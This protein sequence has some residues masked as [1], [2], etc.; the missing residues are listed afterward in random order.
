M[1][2]KF[3]DQD[4]PSYVKIKSIET[5]LTPPISQTTLQVP[6]RYGEYDFGNGIGA[7]TIDVSYFIIADS[8]ADLRTKAREF[9]KWL[10]SDEPKKLVLLD[11]PDK[12][13]WAKVTGNLDLQEAFRTGEGK[14]QFY[15]S[16][17]FAYTDEQGYTFDP[18]NPAILPNGG[19][20][21]TYPRFEF[22]FS[23]PSS[24]FAVY[25]KDK[26]LYFGQPETVDAPAPERKRV[27][28]LDDNCSSV[29]GWTAGV[30]VDGATLY[31][32]LESTGSY[33]RQYNNDF[34]S[35]GTWQGAAGVKTFGGQQLQDFT[36]EAEVAFKS[37]A[38]NQVGRVE[39]Y[40]LDQNNVRIGKMAIKDITTR[41]DD[42]F[43]EARAGAWG[44]GK[45]FVATNVKPGY[46]KQFQGLMRIQRIGKDW[47]FYIGM[48]DSKGKIYR[49]YSAKFYDKDNL[50]SSAKLAGIQI[51]FG[52]RAG[53]AP[54]STMY[55]DHIRVIEENVTI[56]PDA[57]PIIFE[58]G[59]KLVIDCSSGS[60]TLNGEPFYDQLDPSSSFLSLE[61]GDN[62]IAVAPGDKLASAQVFYS[63]RWL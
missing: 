4:L 1:A 14:I 57:P 8:P 26:Y 28:V 44:P 45:Y 38:S 56:Q 51:H 34:G 47:F 20:F 10:Y 63:E 31:G 22:V 11:E 42:P 13:Y 52:C 30:G 19:V 43:I 46:F 59:D 18:L 6:G 17:P 25:N 41:A 32:S 12:Y 39:I 35:G 15:C 61:P 2:I 37:T 40:L 33:I 5:G 24:E 53:S 3:N 54:V 7:R 49:S 55:I 50:Y 21:A 58:S 23:Q 16:D 9:A 27:I 36:V 62:I 29:A 60:I 48:R